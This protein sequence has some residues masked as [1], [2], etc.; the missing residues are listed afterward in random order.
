MESEPYRSKRGCRKHVLTKHSWC[1]YFEKKPDIAKFFPKF[2]TR[3]NIYQLP[4][5]VKTSNIPMF[6]KTC[7]IGVN[8]KKWLQSPGRRGKGES[9]A[10][11]LLCKFL[12]YLKFC[13]ADVSISWDIPES[14][15]DY[16]LGSITM[17]SDFVEYLHTDW[18]LKS[19][20]ITDCTNALEYLLDFFRS[21][22]D[23]TKIHNSVFILSK[24][25]IQRVRS[26][27]STKM[28]SDWREV[29]SVYYLNSLNCWVKLEEL[30]KVI[31]YHSEKYKQIILNA[32]S[33][34]SS[35]AAHDLSFATSF[36][37]ASL[38]LMGKP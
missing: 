34:I 15:V 10:D 26:Y 3:T 11:Q 20:G 12:K 29:L 21:Y 5:Q 6:L 28:K 14:V 36:I 8:F 22:S 1:Y 37:V 9:Q 4:K 7:V 13:C 25:Y 16:C 17:I 24:I 31:P 19:S 23:L 32:S 38:F 33:P 2:S 27:L 18:S 30:Q 35:I